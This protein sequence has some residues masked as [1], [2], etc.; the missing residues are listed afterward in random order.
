MKRKEKITERKGFTLIELLVAIGIVAILAG[1]GVR[2]YSSLLRRVKDASSRT[3]L[4]A[5]NLALHMHRK[6]EGKFPSDGKG[7]DLPAALAAYEVGKP[8]FTNPYDGKS[9]EHLYVRRT[10]GE[11]AEAFVLASPF[12]KAKETMVLLFGREPQKLP[13]R[14][15]THNGVSL[16]PGETVTG[17]TMDFGEGTTV[18]AKPGTKMMLVQSFERADGRPYGLVRVDEVGRVD[19]D[20]ASGWKFEV[21]TP[22]AIAGVEGTEFRVEVVSRTETLIRVISGTVLAIERMG[23]GEVL[24]R[25]GQW[26]RII[27]GELP[28]LEEDEEDDDDDRPGEPD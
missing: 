17:G 7:S 12:V 5:I 1:I 15:V 2:S 14:E 9:Y 22:A 20:V 25:A 13:L 6:D 16:K 11:G 18:K 3:N 10:P 28:Y 27:E 24:V 26:S 8:V 19:V 4:T 21:V 23:K